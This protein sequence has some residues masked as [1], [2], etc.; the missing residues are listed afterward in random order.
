VGP[1]S[2]VH[3]VGRTLSPDFP[4][5]APL[6]PELQDEDYDAFLTSLGSRPGGAG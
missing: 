5:L 6:Q 3:A 4:V 1:D 2:A